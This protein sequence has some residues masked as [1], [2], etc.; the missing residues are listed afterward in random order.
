MHLAVI[1]VNYLN[2]MMSPRAYVKAVLCLW[3]CSK[4]YYMRNLTSSKYQVGR[5]MLLF[6]FQLYELFLKDMLIR[7]LRQEL[8][9]H[10]RAMLVHVC[11]WELKAM[12]KITHLCLGFSI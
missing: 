6:H 9:W 11:M 7:E 3:L 8:L 1:L 2:S 4:Y 12:F 10:L 5:D